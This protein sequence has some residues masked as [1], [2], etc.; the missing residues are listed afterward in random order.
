[1]PESNEATCPLAFES[2]A[3]DACL[4]Y[5]I[6][7]VSL[8]PLVEAERTVRPAVDDSAVD[9]IGVQYLISTHTKEALMKPP[10]EASAETTVSSS[11]L[12]E[13]AQSPSPVRFARRV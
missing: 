9:A 8:P 2:N 4:P 6:E 10:M 3:A 7:V 1:V 12:S 13:A 11:L 5:V